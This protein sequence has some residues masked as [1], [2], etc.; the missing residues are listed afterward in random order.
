MVTFVVLLGQGLDLTLNV[1]EPA[2]KLFHNCS[3]L[4]DA[5]ERSGTKCKLLVDFLDTIVCEVLQTVSGVSVRITCTERGI[6]TDGVG[7]RLSFCL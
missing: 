4:F 2:R 1:V 7:K 3:V 5:L 6:V